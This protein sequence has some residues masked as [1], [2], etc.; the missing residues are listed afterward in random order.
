[1]RLPVKG[2]TI[3][4]LSQAGLDESSPDYGLR[5]FTIAPCGEIPIHKHEYYQTIYLLSGQLVA[6]AH[7]AETDAVLEE[8]SMGPTDVVFVP[9]MEPHSLR[10]PS[11]TEEALFLCCIANI[12]D[13]DAL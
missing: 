9:S 11:E 3:R 7:D 6:V 5:Y 8:R 13:P 4:W 12:C 1:V 2:V 10:N